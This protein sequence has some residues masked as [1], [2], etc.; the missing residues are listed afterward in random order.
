MSHSKLKTQHSKLATERSEA[1]HPAMVILLPEVC[2]FKF[3]SEPMTI[4]A[5]QF[6]EAIGQAHRMNKITQKKVA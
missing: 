1:N 4:T 6:A 2:R 5:I 3:V